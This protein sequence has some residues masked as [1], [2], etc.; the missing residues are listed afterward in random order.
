MKNETEIKFNKAQY[1][2]LAR[3]IRIQMSDLGANDWELKNN[4][5]PILTKLL[6]A[7]ARLDEPTPKP[8]V[9]NESSDL[10]MTTQDHIFPKWFLETVQEKK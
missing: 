2:Y 5:A 3:G 9:K 8:K 7:I 4:L 10:R 1:G 6:K